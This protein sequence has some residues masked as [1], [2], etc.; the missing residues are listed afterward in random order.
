M[1]RRLVSMSENGE[2]RQPEMAIVAP[3]TLISKL[4]TAPR[5]PAIVDSTDASS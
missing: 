3:W 2:Y 1:N 4:A 5:G